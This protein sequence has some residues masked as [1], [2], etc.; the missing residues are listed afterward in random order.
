[1]T[2]NLDQ[3]YRYKKYIAQIILNDQKCVDLLTNSTYQGELP[4]Q[5]LL[6]QLKEDQTYVSGQVHL[7]DYIP[8]P[9]TEADSH[10]CIEIDDIGTNTVAVGEY[11]IEINIIVP[12]SLMN[13]YG[14]IRR[15]ALASRIDYLI[16]GDKNLGFGR[17]K[18]RMGGTGIPSVKFRS[19]RLRYMVQDFN[20]ADGKLNP[21]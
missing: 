4:A 13:M 15:D 2:E 12:I 8:D 14:N 20:I 10:I 7:Y 1:M 11:Q 3:Y 16:N 5:E 21:S 17:V 9:E 19:R 6:E 18:R